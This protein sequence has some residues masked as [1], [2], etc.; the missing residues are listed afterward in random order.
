MRKRRRLFST[1]H[2]HHDKKMFVHALKH[3]CSIPLCQLPVPF[4]MDDALAITIPK[5]EYCAGLEAC[6]NSLRDA[7]LAPKGIG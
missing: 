3:V 1:R 2:Y 7:I 4:L 5:E 6:K